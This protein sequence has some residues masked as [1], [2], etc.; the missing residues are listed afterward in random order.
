MTALYFVAALV[1]LSISVTIVLFQIAYIVN[2]DE[3]KYLMRYTAEGF[4]VSAVVFG[5]FGNFAWI[6]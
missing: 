3:H 1:S 6:N 4:G 2:D 5:L